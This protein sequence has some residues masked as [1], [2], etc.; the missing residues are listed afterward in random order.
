MSE[1]S[2]NW[3]FTLNNYTDDD[4]NIIGGWLCK[5]LIYGKEVGQNGTPHLQGYV[6]MGKPTRL[7]GMKKM[8]PRMHFEKRMGT[9]EQAITYCKKDNMF[10]E[11][12]QPGRQGERT[13]LNEMRDRIMGGERIEDIMMENPMMHHMYGRTLSRIEDIRMRRLYRTEMTTCEWLHGPTGVGKSHRAFANFSPET[14]YVWKNDNGWQDAYMQQEIVII[15]DFRGEI[16]YN[17]LL[18]M[19]DKWPYEV[20]RRGR[21]PM[22]FMSKHII[23]TSSLTPDQVY[24]QQLHKED[25]INQLL[26]RIVVTEVLRG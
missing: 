3:C 4:E 8:H 22:P 5:Y 1:V 14:H 25:S 6:E 7:S 13:D 2:R 15:N 10:V 11:I 18:Q 21:E 19:I 24:R 26:R 9:Q 16:P 20:R 17:E 23:I 12:G